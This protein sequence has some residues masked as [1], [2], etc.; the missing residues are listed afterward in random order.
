MF[1]LV[2]VAVKVFV[3]VLSSGYSTSSNY[4]PYWDPSFVVEG[5]TERTC[6]L[7]L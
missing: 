5:G 3:F 7:A 2:F 1:V 4:C 6:I